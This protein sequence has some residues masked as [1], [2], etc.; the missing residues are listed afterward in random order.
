LRSDRSHESRQ[1]CLLGVRIALHIP[2][3]VHRSDTMPF[4]SLPDHTH[5]SCGGSARTIHSRDPIEGWCATQA[6]EAGLLV[7]TVTI[8]IFIPQPKSKQ[9]NGSPAGHQHRSLYFPHRPPSGGMPYSSTSAGRF[10]DGVGI[11]A[12]APRR[13]SV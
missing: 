12:R 10:S 11:R 7:P 9:L 6:D 4:G 1:F 8:G 5:N 13:L 3:S 2:R